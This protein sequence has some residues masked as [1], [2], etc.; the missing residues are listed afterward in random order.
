MSQI[1]GHAYNKVKST[2]RISGTV[3]LYS[4]PAEIIPTYHDYLLIG[5]GK[6][7]PSVHRARCIENGWIKEEDKNLVVN[8][9]LNQIVLLLN[10][11]SATNFQSC[12]VGSGTST[13][14]A[15]DT[16]LTTPITR[17]SVTAIYQSANVGHWDTF[18]N[19]TTGT[20]T[21]G[22][23]GLFSTNTLASGIML[24]KKLFTSTFPKTTSN[25]STVA[26]TLTVTAV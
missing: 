7:F 21:W 25:T 19:S 26:W 2:F 17:I 14:L 22:E 20:G 8:A 24:C 23:A 9:G 5:E 1:V 16:D 13:V 6:A 15:T 12:G 4:F 18:F 11:G 10:G 3:T